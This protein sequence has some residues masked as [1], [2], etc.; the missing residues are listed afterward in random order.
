MGCRHRKVPCHFEET[1]TRLLSESMFRRGA[2]TN[3][4]NACAIQKQKQSQKTLRA[5]ADLG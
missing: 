2:E 1:R 4:R 5:V 3:T